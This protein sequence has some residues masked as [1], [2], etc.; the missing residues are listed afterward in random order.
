MG[1]RSRRGV[2]ISLRFTRSSSPA[3][4]VTAKALQLLSISSIPIAIRHESASSAHV[5]SLQMEG[6]MGVFL[7]CV[8]LVVHHGK[9]KLLLMQ[10]R[11]PLR[12]RRRRRRRRT[13]EA[14]LEARSTSASPSSQP[15]DGRREWEGWRANRG[16]WRPGPPASATA[17][18]VWPRFF[19]SAAVALVGRRRRRPR[20]GAPF[21]EAREEWTVITP[22][23][24]QQG[25]SRVLPPLLH[26]LP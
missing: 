13:S 9:R 22:R 15:R 18:D 20:Q 1:R 17:D 3:A 4:G 23:W 7:V 8:R 2:F 21:G 5:F 25:A 12:R 26:R 19:V 10:L 24:G 16:G 14:P 11:P 6:I